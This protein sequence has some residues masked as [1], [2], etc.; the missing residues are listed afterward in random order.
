MSDE[1]IDDPELE[2]RLADSF[3]HHADALVIADRPFDLDGM[4]TAAGTPA[5]TGTLLTAPMPDPAA[6]PEPPRELDLDVIELDPERARRRRPV[7][8][9]WLAG[10]AAAVVLVGALVAI[11]RASDPEVYLGPDGGPLAPAETAWV[12]SW[13]PDGLQL[14]TVGAAATGDP[15]AAERTSGIQRSAQL[16]ESTTGSG[17]LLVGTASSDAPPEE[18][19]TTLTARGTTISVSEGLEAWGGDPLPA[20]SWVEGSGRVHAVSRDLSDE[21]TVELLDLLTLRD[22]ADPLAGFSVPDGSPW[23]IREA[24]APP[25]RSGIATFFVYDR[26]T[27]TGTTEAPLQ[28]VING[29]GGGYPDYLSAAITGRID[30]EGVAVGHIPTGPDN[31]GAPTTVLVWPDGRSVMVYGGEGIDEATAEQVARSIQPRSLDDLRA[32]DAEV[33]ERVA[34]SGSVLAAGDLPD[35]RVEVIGAADPTGICVTVFGTRSC[36]SIGHRSGLDDE[37][38]PLLTSAV[39]GGTWYAFGADPGPVRIETGGSGRF[40]G[41]GIAIESTDSSV[42]PR[43]TAD[44]I[45]VTVEGDVV[46]TTTADPTAS[47]T[48]P[49]AEDLEPTGSESAGASVPDPALVRLAPTVTVGG[50][51]FALLAVPDGVDGVEA[52][53]DR[54]GSSMSRPL[55]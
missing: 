52:T 32:M 17:A 31:A 19:A 12:P 30:D 22:P 2:A 54:Y 36:R 7:P 51:T 1:W 3:R 24:P 13:V 20:L 43:S 25:A 21:A 39:I 14:W 49:S 44:S 45:E 37:V 48:T 8:L 29:V 40:T 53:F 38:D 55:I 26:S 35:G 15:L 9:V 16:I 4:A 47:T 27:P 34:A 50:W 42:T 10:A 41:T 28:V 11:N 23:T 6:E 18:T 46:P 33:S 5:S